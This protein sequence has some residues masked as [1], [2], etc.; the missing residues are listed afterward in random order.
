MLQ[1]P[2]LTTTE[3]EVECFKECDLHKWSDNGGKC[4]FVELK[5]FKPFIINNIT[6]YDIFS[7]DGNSQLKSL[8]KDRYL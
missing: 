6:D 3:E 7:E 5:D 4:P 1:C 8:Y 2:F